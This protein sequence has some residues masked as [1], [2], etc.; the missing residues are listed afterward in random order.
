M[1]RPDRENDHGRSAVSWLA[2]CFVS[3]LG[4]LTCTLIVAALSDHPREHLMIGAGGVAGVVLLIWMLGEK[5]KG[6]A[7]QGRRFWLAWRKTAPLEVE[8]TPRRRRRS[9]RGKLGTN[10]PPDV[11][12]IRALSDDP[13]NWVPSGV[14]GSEKPAN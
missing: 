11:E 13:H 1:T 2:T 8:Y 3:G 14:D 12:T 6:A 4:L 5:P 7:D 9:R 10:A